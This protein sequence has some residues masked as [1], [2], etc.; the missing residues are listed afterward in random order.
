RPSSSPAPPRRPSPRGPRPSTCTRATRPAR[1]RWPPPTS[2]RRSPR[3]APR[4]PAP[5]SACPP[6]CG[7]A[8][9]AR[10]PRRP[11]RPPWAGGAGRPGRACARVNVSERGWTQLVT[12]LHGAG[13]GV[14]AGVWPVPDAR[15]LAA[16]RRGAPLVRI[17][18]E[19]ID[20]PAATATERADQILAEL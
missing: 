16:F 12:M 9:G 2:G 7:S 13:V 10:H 3:S 8:A 11:P 5:L 14:G 15:A 20:E 17:L 1:N 4:V 19:V 18:V 6:G